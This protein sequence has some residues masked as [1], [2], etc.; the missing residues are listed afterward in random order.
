MATTPTSREIE[1]G[2]RLDVR[3][4]LW[5][6]ATGSLVVADLHWGYAASHRAAGNLLPAWGDAAIAAALDALVADYQ[7]REMIWLGDVIHAAA[8]R[9][10]AEAYLHAAKV[11][12]VVLRGNHDRAW[13]H[14]PTSTALERAGF[15]LHHGDA[16]LPSL[17]TDRRE[18][19]GHHH[20]AAV[21]DDRAGARLRLPAL[22]TGPRRWIMPAFSPWAA[23]VAWNR[24]LAPDE[25]LWAISPR[26]IVALL[27]RPIVGRRGSP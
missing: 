1:S 27:P 22:V 21:W 13:Q 16:V 25:T 9:A 15:V 26:R 10:R 8:G 12:V 2:V 6:A 3:R 24:Q 17:P 20:P 19:V 4:A 5:L 7:P 14:Q 18:L 23:G 11:P